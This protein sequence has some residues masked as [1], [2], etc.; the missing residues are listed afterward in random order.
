MGMR[1]SEEQEEEEPIKQVLTD[2]PGESRERA[3]TVSAGV[4]SAVGT[5]AGTGSATVPASQARKMRPRTRRALGKMAAAAKTVH[6]TVRLQ[7]DLNRAA[8]RSLR[9]MSVAERMLRRAQQALQTARATGDRA[10]ATASA[11]ALE[12]AQ[13]SF[14]GAMQAGTDAVDS[15]LRAMTSASLAKVPKMGTRLLDL[16][17]STS[18]WLSASHSPAAPLRTSLPCC[19]CCPASHAGPGAARGGGQGHLRQRSEADAVQATDG[20]DGPAHIG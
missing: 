2:A 13:L 16:K 8:R 7:R 19:D 11:A 9:R 17:V 12:A 20:V 6:A 15:A 5:L 4:V 10:A 1:P 18:P 3:V 14:Q